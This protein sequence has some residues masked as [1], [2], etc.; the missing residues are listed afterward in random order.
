[1]I[2]PEPHP[3]AG[4][5]VELVDARFLIGSKVTIEDWYDRL[6]GRSWQERRKPVE[7]IYGAYATRYGLPLDDEV[8]YGKNE[9]DC[10][11]ILH[12]SEIEYAQMLALLDALRG[13]SEHAA[14][15][16][17]AKRKARRG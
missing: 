2:H 7:V 9:N 3:Q 4:Q 8:V 6:D 13:A 15:A 12:Q 14:A 10:G 17:A 16:K 1:M 5:T 11:C